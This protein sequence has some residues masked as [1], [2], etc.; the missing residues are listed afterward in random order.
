MNKPLTDEE[1]ARIE[2]AQKERESKKVGKN[3]D[4]PTKV[5]K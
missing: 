4:G 2:K 5:R 1:R 3:N